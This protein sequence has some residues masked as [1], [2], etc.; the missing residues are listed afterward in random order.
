[1]HHVSSNGGMLARTVKAKFHEATM[2]HDEIRA[3]IHGQMRETARLQAIQDGRL[4]RRIAG[5]P[6]VQATGLLIVAVILV[7]GVLPWVAK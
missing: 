1:L 5:N 3:V 2:T 6:F 4:I 7:E